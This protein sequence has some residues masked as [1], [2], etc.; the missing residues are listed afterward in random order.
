MFIQNKDFNITNLNILP[1]TKSIVINY[2]KTNKLDPLQK[3]TIESSICSHDEVFKK[4]VKNNII[5]V[6][7]NI[8]D[9]KSNFANYI[10]LCNGFVSFSNNFVNIKKDNFKIIEQKF[11]SGNVDELNNITKLIEY[12]IQKTLKF[13]AWNYLS[14]IMRYNKDFDRAHIISRVKIGIALTNKINTMRRG[15]KIC[16]IKD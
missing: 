2:L 9:H 1:S 4:P 6:K 3:L 10:R 12:Y 14:A 8:L 13:K 16:Q 5:V 15:V 11:N 7:E